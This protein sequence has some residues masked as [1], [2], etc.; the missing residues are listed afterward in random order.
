MSEYLTPLHQRCKKKGNDYG[1]DYEVCKDFENK[2]DFK[3]AADIIE[4]R[5]RRDLFYLKIDRACHAGDMEELETCMAEDEKYIG[6][7][8]DK[9]GY[10]RLK[11]RVRQA[12]N[13]QDIQASWKILNEAF[14]KAEKEK[15]QG[16]QTVAEET[17]KMVH[18][19]WSSWKQ[20][21]RDAWY[22]NRLRIN[23]REA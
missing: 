6:K 10:Q 1:I 16:S 19:G 21:K 20:K 17:G 11:C 13:E 5:E 8:Y 22:K 3:H 12:A 4:E 15:T 18:G 23:K 2:K 7:K 9:K 14:E